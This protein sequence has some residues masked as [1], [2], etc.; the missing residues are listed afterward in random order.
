MVTV[1]E[2]GE[3]VFELDAPLA[4][5]VEVIGNFRGW[6]EIGIPM[7]RARDGQWKLMID[8]GPGEHLF[9]Y[10][11]DESR[12][13]L[14]ADAHGVC[15]TGDGTLKCRVWCPPDPGRIAA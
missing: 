6:H 10:R 2:N 4:R 7:S 9:R 11:I 8:P 5:D 3:V 1:G 13:A 15:R 14:D 12:Y